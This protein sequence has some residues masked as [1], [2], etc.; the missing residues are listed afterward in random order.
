[1]KKLVVDRKRLD[2]EAGAASTENIPVK[3]RRAVLTEALVASLKADIGRSCGSC[4]LCCKLLGVNDPPVFKP[5]GKWCPHCRPGRGGCAIYDRR[6]NSCRDWTCGWL[7]NSTL[8]DEWQ[9]TRCK[10]VVHWEPINEATQFTWCNILVDPGTPDA[11]R[12]EPYH[13][14]IRMWALNGLRGVNGVTIGTRVLVGRQVFIIVPDDDV[15]VPLG[16]S[17]FTVE[18]VGPDQWKVVQFNSQDRWDAFM[19]ALTE[20]G[21][22]DSVARRRRLDRDGNRPSRRCRWGSDGSTD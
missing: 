7:V 21:R 11:W 6:P 14:Q 10:M 13:S 20:R 1:M 4:S 22:A 16:N 17:G 18:W 5:A 3:V 2:D 19:R 12:R 9:P 15:E 8:G